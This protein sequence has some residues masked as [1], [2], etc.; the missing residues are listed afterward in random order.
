M[1]YL[2]LVP[3]IAFLILLLAVW[4]EY[5][6]LALLALG[7]KWE[8]APGKTKSYACGE[9]MPTNRV[10]PDYSQFFSFAFFFTIMHVVALVAATVPGGATSASLL[11]AVYLVAS[12]I[13]LFILYRR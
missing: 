10:Q 11:A 8:S 5:R 3:P 1:D 12:A 7:E 6:G 13:G 2:L 9:D 4:I